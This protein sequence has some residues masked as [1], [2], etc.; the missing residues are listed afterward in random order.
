MTPLAWRPF[1]DPAD[2]FSGP[3]WLLCLPPLVFASAM[4]YHA[5]RQEK[6]LSWPVVLRQSTWMAG[7]ALAVLGALVALL[8]FL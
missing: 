8:W 5:L 3:G 6:D 2:L 1:V 7:K 4:V